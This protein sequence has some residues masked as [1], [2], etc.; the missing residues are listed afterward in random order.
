MTAHQSAA[1]RT[2]RQGER[3]ID[4]EMAEVARTADES[5]CGLESASVSRLDRGFASDRNPELFICIR[6]SSAP[7]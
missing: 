5:V 2:R 1:G 4:R 6:K 3:Q 7:L